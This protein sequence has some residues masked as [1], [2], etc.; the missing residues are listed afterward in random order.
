M[1]SEPRPPVII[2]GE[3]SHHNQLPPEE[4]HKRFKLVSTV[5][6]GVFGITILGW[7][8]L[9]PA[10]GLSQGVLVAYEDATPFGVLLASM[11]KRDIVRSALLTRVFVQIY[12]DH[13]RIPAGEYYIK[14]GTWLPQIAKQL[15]KGDY[16]IPTVKVTFP[17]G[18]TNREMAELL[19]EKLPGFDTKAFLTFAEKE[20]GYLFPNTYDFFATVK[21]EKIVAMLREEFATQVEVLSPELRASGKTEKEMIIM[22]S[23]LE[24][25]VKTEED[26]RIVSGILW[27]RIAKG[28]PLQ[29]DATFVYL[30]GK[31]SEDLTLTDLSV[32]SPYN[33]YRNKGLPPGPINNPGIDAMRTAVTPEDSPYFFYLSDKDGVTHYAKTFDEHKANKAKYLR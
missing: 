17:E 26:R 10:D 3:P 8:F 27:K 23:I 28:M 31:G 15:A 5:I 25:E 21:P 1:T 30:L 6:I 24:G 13:A 11:E 32:D 2:I 29:V 22:A 33:T 9:R 16:Q 19:A 4:K 20:E 12:G 7:F 18:L 14:E